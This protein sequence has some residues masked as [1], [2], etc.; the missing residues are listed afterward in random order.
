MKQATHAATGVDARLVASHPIPD[1]DALVVWLQEN[2]E[3]LDQ[4]SDLAPA[5]VPKL[6]DAGL[7][8]VGVPLEYG[9]SGGT[10]LHAIETVAAVA[11]HSLTAAFV[12]WGQRAFIEC[13]LA[14]DNDALRDAQL[15]A[16]LTG[17]RAGAVGLSNAMKFLA[18]M[19]G[20]LQVVARPAGDACRLTGRLAFVTNLRREGYV[21]AL[22]AASEAGGPPAIYAVSDAM[23]GVARSEDLDLIALR[24]SNTAG[25]TLDDVRVDRGWRIAADGPGFLARLRPRFLGLQCG[26]SIGLARR[27]LRTLDS[28]G[29]AT[30]AMLAGEGLTLET[31]LH[32]LVLDLFDGIEAGEFV[33]RPK[34]LFCLRLLLATL[35]DEAVSL[36]VLGAG[37]RGYLRGGAEVARRRREAAFIPIV[38]PSVVQL[39][40]AMSR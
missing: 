19:D 31:E 39:R 7:L 38:T 28:T 16:A 3:R 37:S 6:A 5:V 14:T 11:E 15:P 1:M 23:P 8:R 2:A 27:S 22:A 36:E 40:R 25:L 20:A 35:V 10:I 4:Q 24:A 34:E 26:L 17:E 13:L 32:G 29:A 21:V 9:G 18:Q 30:R 33:E 12:L